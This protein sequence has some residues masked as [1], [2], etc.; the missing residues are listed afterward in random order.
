MAAPTRLARL[1]RLT[2]VKEIAQIG[3]VIGREFGS[4][5]LAATAQMDEPKLRTALDELIRAE[6]AFCRGARRWNRLRV[7][8]VFHRIQLYNK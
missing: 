6:L 7:T 8:D 1:N 3:A 5:S 4:E 2:P